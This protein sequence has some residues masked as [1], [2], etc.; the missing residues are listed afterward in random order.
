MQ[1]VSVVAMLALLAGCMAPPSRSAGAQRGPSLGQSLTT[2]SSSVITPYSSDASD[3]EEEA[4]LASQKVVKI[5]LLVPLSGRNAELGKA[6]RD[7]AAVSLFDKYARLSVRAQTVR[8]ELLPKDTGDTT[9]QATIAMNQALEEGAQFIIGPLFADAAA[10][11]APQARAKNINVL[12]FSNT[13]TQASPG[14]YMFGFSPAEQ[15]ERIVSYALANGKTKIAVLAPNSPLG[16]TVLTAARGVAMKFGVK[17]TAEAKYMLQ[18]A[19]MDTALNTLV[20]PGK[21]PAFDAI[22]IPEG[23]AALDTI[24]RGLSARGVKPSTVQFL[25]TGLWDD[26]DLLRRVNLDTAW[27]ASSSPIL[28]GQFETRFRTTYG[29]APPRIASLAYDAVALAVTLATS[30]RPFDVVTLTSPAGFSG[31]ANGIFRLRA[32]GTTQRGLAVMQVQGGGLKIISPAPN[33]F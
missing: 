33:G 9:E 5:G 14:T 18:G 8:V 25:G 20:M 10:A 30:S 1:A 7:A 31:P 16:E 22:L 12:S 17:L 23:G 27:F 21:T 11:S 32:D 2:G 13:R 15:T 28:T 6:L 26:A 19:G 3:V 4:M 24:L 29:Y